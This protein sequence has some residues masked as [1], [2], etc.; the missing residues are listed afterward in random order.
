MSW[1]VAR[2]LR[3]IMTPDHRFR[4][5]THA[6]TL[7]KQLEEDRKPLSACELFWKE[8][9]VAVVVKIGRK[10]SRPEQIL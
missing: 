5:V 6:F 4:Q 3:R 9:S 2:I 10:F 7:S 8:G 1:A